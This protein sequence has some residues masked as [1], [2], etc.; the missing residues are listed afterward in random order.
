ME[1]QLRTCGRVLKFNELFLCDTLLGFLII[2]VRIEV[3][4]IRSNSYN[5]RSEIWSRA[6]TSSRKIYENFSYFS[7]IWSVN[8][9]KFDLESF[10]M[11]NVVSLT[12]FANMEN[13]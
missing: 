9:S 13:L 6:L 4:L 1:L 10:M 5:I 3:N 2:S 7:V 12:C 8:S 11:K